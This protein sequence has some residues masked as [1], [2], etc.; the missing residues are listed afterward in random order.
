MRPANNMDVSHHPDMFKEADL[1][2]LVVN[3]T[4][5]PKFFIQKDVGQN[6]KRI[7]TFNKIVSTRFIP[8][9]YV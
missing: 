2:F 6:I 1:F 5:E 3:S 4:S 8:L 9:Y 7:E